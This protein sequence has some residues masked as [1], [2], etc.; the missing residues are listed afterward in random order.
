[1]VESNIKQRQRGDKAEGLAETYLE[2]AGYTILARNYRCP[3][4]EIDLIA[5]EYFSATAV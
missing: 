2:S 4:G 1:M 3:Q 5:S